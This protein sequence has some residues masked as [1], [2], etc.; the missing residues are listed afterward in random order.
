MMAKRAEPASPIW[1]GSDMR[2]EWATAAATTSSKSSASNGLMR[3][4]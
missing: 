3:Y 4:S 2:R 1:M